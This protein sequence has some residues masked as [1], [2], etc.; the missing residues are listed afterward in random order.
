MFVTTC[1]ALQRCWQA[2]DAMFETIQDWSVQ[3]IDVR[4]PFGFYYGHLA[5]FAKLK[6]MPA[7]SLHQISKDLEEGPIMQHADTSS[8]TCH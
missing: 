8:V 1:E 4:R 3:P 2:T 6:V 7:V 5:S